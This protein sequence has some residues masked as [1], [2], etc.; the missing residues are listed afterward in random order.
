MVIT[1]VSYTLLILLG[2]TVFFSPLYSLPIK[3][4]LPKTFLPDNPSLLIGKSS[5]PRR[6]SIIN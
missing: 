5:G 6:I 4:F 2:L 3:S 1:K